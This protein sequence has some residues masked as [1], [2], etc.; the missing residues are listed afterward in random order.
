MYPR[1]PV[2]ASHF[3]SFQEQ[4][5]SCESA[6]LLNP[7]SFNLTGEREPERIEGATCTW[8]LFQLLGV[9]PHLG[10]TFAESD[11]QP[12]ANKFVVISDSLWRRRLG[13][14]PGI[15]GK[16]I[17][18][19]GEPHIVVGVLRADFRFPSGD[20]LGPLNQFPKHAEIFKPMGFN[21]AKLGRLGQFN[22]AALVRLR[23]G[24]NPA[25]AE[26][27]MTASV[28]DAGRDMKIDLS[29]HLVPL[30]EQITGGSRRALTFLF[31][32]VGAVLLIVCVNLG[33]LML[34]R[35]GE[36]ARDA[37]IRRALG[38][39]TGQLFRP[40]VTESL[41]IALS[42]GALGILLAFAGVQILVT[43]APVDIPRLD[44]IRVN[45][46]TLL[47]AFAVSAGCGIVCGLWPAIRATR[48]EPADALRSGSRSATEGR[49]RQRSREWLV[50]L[51]VALST[52]LLVVA[53][54]LGVSF[55]RVTSVERGM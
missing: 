47:F 50:G 43:T 52:V 27:E 54:L 45:F 29:A 46:S 18:L 34:V 4:C 12:G 15:V 35:A 55:F 51:E 26:A 28:A 3:R 14:D 9:E 44:E 7:A 21:W 48:V 42:G 30:Q 8:P 16:P 5:R 39:D 37:A 1:L 53:S 49:A 13:A 17:Q 33:N 6:A 36:R 41:V 31:A 22:F 24:V 23:P 40:I 19:D 10:R 2:N 11:D 32:A 20:K 25:R 38:A